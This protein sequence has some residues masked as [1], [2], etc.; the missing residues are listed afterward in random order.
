L[1]TVRIAR[2]FGTVSELLPDGVSYVDAPH[3]FASAIK[4][5]AT[6]LSWGENIE[7]KY[8]PPKR[9][10]LDG[11]KLEAHFKRVEKLREDE[12][13]GRSSTVEGWDGTDMV[14]NEAARALIVG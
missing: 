6:F 10:W 11:E 13:K 4:M 12:L 9:I 1:D 2:D 5:A 14:D 3:P 7:Q 8:M